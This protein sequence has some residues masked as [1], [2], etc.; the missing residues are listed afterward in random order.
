[1]KTYLD[2]LPENKR[3]EMRDSNLT[4]RI[5]WQEIG[6]AFPVML[7]I[8]YLAAANYALDI[9]LMSEE[10]ISNREKT[11]VGQ[12]EIAGHENHFEEIN[13]K[14]GLLDLID[15]RHFNW[16]VV[17]Q[18]IAQQV[19]EKVYLKSLATVNYT[20]SV[21]G[22]AEQRQDFLNF[23]KAL[24]ESECFENI[25]DPLSNLV[26]RRDLDFTLEFDVKKECL[27]RHE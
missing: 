25:Q 14:T 17:L 1:M 2:L 15:S 6:L 22:W 21:M 23:Q 8:I 24:G 27:Q 18:K 20:V 12:I 3:R 9:R 4:R 26:S 16:N 13:R 7:L 5:I 11:S 19:P 10:D